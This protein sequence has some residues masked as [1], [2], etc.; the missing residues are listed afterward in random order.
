VASE[1]RNPLRLRRVPDEAGVY[2]TEHPLR[3]RY[4]QAIGTPK[5][6]FPTR[7]ELSTQARTA[8]RFVEAAQWLVERLPLGANVTEVSDD[9][10]SERERLDRGLNLIDLYG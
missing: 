5:W 4:G 7:G 6:T 8:M 9:L 2:F 1:T 3:D 10:N